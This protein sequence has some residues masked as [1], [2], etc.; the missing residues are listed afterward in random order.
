MSAYPLDANKWQAV[1]DEFT[2]RGHTDVRG[3]TL[4]DGNFTPAQVVDEYERSLREIEAMTPEEFEAACIDLDDDADLV[5]GQHIANLKTWL[6]A[7][8]R[9]ERDNDEPDPTF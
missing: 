7:A 2:R 1:Q 8:P 4:G 3:F 6:S 5:S 9:T